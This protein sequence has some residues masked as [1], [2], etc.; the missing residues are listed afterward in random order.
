MKHK[1]HTAKYWNN[2]YYQ[3]WEKILALRQENKKL[4]KMIL[5]GETDKKLC[6]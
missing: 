2:K 3:L 1:I 4:V 6:R 5:K